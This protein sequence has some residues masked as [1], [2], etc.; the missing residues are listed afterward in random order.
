MKL[1]RFGNK[2]SEKPGLLDS[3]GVIRDLSRHI[4]DLDGRHL[5][6]RSLEALAKLDISSLPP[7]EGKVRLGPCVATPGK[8]IAIGLNYSDHA[9]E[10]GLPIPEEPVVFFKT[11]TCINGPYDDVIQPMDSTK[12]DWELEIAIVVGQKAQYV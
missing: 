1:V 11:D 6:P 9:A 2:N 7:V 10:T 3:G 5:T 4:E 8:F 12:L